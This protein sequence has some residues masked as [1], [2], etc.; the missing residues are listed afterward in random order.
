MKGKA[1]RLLSL[2]LAGGLLLAQPALAQ[3]A[4]LPLGG[5]RADPEAPVEI[6]ADSLAVSQADGRAVFTGNVLVAQGDLK[7]SAGKV[8]VAYDRPAEGQGQGKI[9]TLHATGGVTLASPQEA[10]EAQE[11]VYD[12][13][14]HRV[15]MT[16]KVLLTQGQNT[17]AGES[18]VV[19]LDTGTG[20]MQ[21]RVR[22]TLTPGG[23]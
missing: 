15:T 13:A 7:L 4:T 2:A 16:G 12:V 14:A 11:A 22:T 20:T 18:L 5:L 9:R 21:G 19:D 8:E 17:I 10:A 6:E 23:N 1:M 3:Q